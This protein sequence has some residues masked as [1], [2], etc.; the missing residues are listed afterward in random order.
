MTD[1]G[2][3]SSFMV[4]EVIPGLVVPGSIRK[5]EQAMGEQANKQ[6]PSMASASAPASRFL[7]CLSSCHDFV[8]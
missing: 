3:P 2:G 8:Q 5:A 7:P 6:H 4:V 1:G